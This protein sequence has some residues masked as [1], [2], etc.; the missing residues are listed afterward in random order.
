MLFP[1]GSEDACTVQPRNHQRQPSP[2]SGGSTHAS[3]RASDIPPVSAR[4]SSGGIGGAQ[5]MKRTRNRW[6]VVLA[7][8]PIASEEMATEICDKWSM[9]N[10]GIMKKTARGEALSIVYGIRGYVDWSVVFG[11]SDD[12]HKSYDV[13]HD[14]V[15]HVQ[16][17]T[18]RRGGVFGGSEHKRKCKKADATTNSSSSLRTAPTGADAIR[19]DGNRGFTTPT[20]PKHVGHSRDTDGNERPQP[21]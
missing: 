15:P 3:Q 2:S 11:T 13:V 4:S 17:K 12:I 21:T 6:K 9:N 18:K 20:Q 19:T 7:M 8:G 10:R 14:D 5:R 16:S 1:D